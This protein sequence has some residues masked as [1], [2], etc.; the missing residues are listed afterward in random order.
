MGIR[1][2]SRHLKEIAW[3]RENSGGRTQP[4]GTKMPNAFGLHDMYGNV[5]EWCLD[6]LG[7]YSQVP[8]TDPLGPAKG[9]L[10]ILRG[11]AYN[12]EAAYVRSTYRGRLSPSTRQK[13]VGLRVV[14]RPR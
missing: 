9:K 4:T 8:Q 11:G 12:Y 13:H 14:A 1:G 7:D 6:W 5:W 10:R 2:E 3:Y